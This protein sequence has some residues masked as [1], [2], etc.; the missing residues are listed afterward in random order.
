MLFPP[1]YH[2][3]A[4]VHSNSWGVNIGGYLFDDAQI[5][6]FAYEHQDMLIIYAGG[7][8]GE[9][10]FHSIG[11]PGTTKNALTVGAT[12]SGPE[13]LTQSREVVAKFSS[14]GPTY[15]GRLK[16]DVVAPGAYVYSA[17][18][19]GYDNGG[20][21]AYVAMA[22]T[23][24][25]APIVAGVAALLRQYFKEGHYAR[26][27]TRRG[28]CAPPYT[29]GEAGL[30]PSA[31]LLKALFVNSAVPV[32]AFRL[33]PRPTTTTTT[34][35]S[36]SSSKGEEEMEE[37]A[38][39]PLSH[40]PD[41]AQGHGRVKI[42]AA[43]DFY[44]AHSLF[45]ADRRALKSGERHVYYFRIQEEEAV[46]GSGSG[47]VPLQV[48]LAWIDP[49][50][51]FTARKQLLHDLDLLVIDPAGRP[52]HPNGLPGPDERNNV[53]KV[54]IPPEVLVS[55]GVYRLVVRAGEL[56]EAETQAY[57]LVATGPGR[58]VVEAEARA[59]LPAGDGVDDEQAAAGAAAG[60][61]GAVSL[62]AVLHPCFTPLLPALST[63]LCH[64]LAS[65]LQAATADAS[66]CPAS[67]VAETRELCLG[68]HARCG[69]EACGV[70]LLPVASL[71]TP[72]GV[73]ARMQEEE[74]EQRSYKVAA[75]LVLRGLKEEDFFPP[76]PLVLGGTGEEGE[77]AGLLLLRR[78]LVA[79]L[80]R[81]LGLMGKE[82]GDGGGSSSN[83]KA[84]AV[85]LVHVNGRAL[86]S[87][88]S[89]TGEEEDR[90]SES[91]HTR[92]RRLLLFGPSD[93]APQFSSPH[94]GVAVGI[95]VLAPQG[96]AQG[97]RLQAFMAGSYGH[98]NDHLR[99]SVDGRLRRALAFD[100]RP[101]V[102]SYRLLPAAAVVV[103]GGREME[104]EEVRQQQQQLV[105][106]E[107]REEEAQEEG[108]EGEGGGGVGPDAAVVG[109][110]EMAA[111]GMGGQRGGSGKGGSGSGSGRAGGL[112]ASP[113]LMCLSIT[114]I[115][116]GLASLAMEGLR[117]WLPLSGHG[118][119]GGRRKFLGMG[120]HSAQV[121]TEGVVVMGEKGVSG[122]EGGGGGHGGCCKVLLV[123]RSRCSTEDEEL[124]EEESRR[125]RQ[126]TA[127]ALIAEE[128][129]WARVRAR[130]TEEGEEEEEEEGARVGGEGE[131]EGVVVA[132]PNEE[133]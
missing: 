111:S 133:G 46:G 117:R 73:Q 23:S 96:R 35:S 42:D 101:H 129:D 12:E 18:S 51:A 9:Q 130:T 108:G 75:R 31:P 47:G 7:N 99:A 39:V 41:L 85:R 52:H 14:R 121:H 116:L 45:L 107:R 65:A 87:S 126:R 32:K 97:R 40:P 63:S 58:A 72:T 71:E 49:P 24:M 77:E 80:G 106:D 61:A 20:T 86:P 109:T 123:A 81:W 29:C 2:A 33:P 25:A 17:R 3:G 11:S 26:A 19:S 56:T 119:Q 115:V 66:L 120:K 48:A 76:P 68:P 83:D 54:V 36:S 127:D 34:S 6:R 89:T 44:G 5:D 4:R 22:G 98:L 102:A 59:S 94:Y 79:A 91:D 67:A 53:E 90:E 10:G 37:E 88:P 122:G 8:Y 82:K 1:A 28:E 128:F 103:G 21:C 112:L 13:R 105:F 104:G 70:A 50:N 15:D 16:P 43:L 60:A 92:G 113:L 69:L 38:L 62:D 84:A 132:Q 110:I 64:Q 125:E 100:V 30:E 93:P 74:E 124:E 95:E 118:G 55:G 131:G 78:E 57:A 114:L 27:L